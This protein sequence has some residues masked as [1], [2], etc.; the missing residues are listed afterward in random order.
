MQ[1]NSVPDELLS[2][3]EQIDLLDDELLMILAKRFEV[4]EQVGRLKAKEG[5]NSLD[6]DR[7]NQKLKDLK[8]NAESKGLSA[9]FV[10]N[11]FK[12]IFAEVVENH[13]GFLQ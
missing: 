7:E 3:R 13:R 9:D 8:L 5:L 12:M 6:E 10:L 2:L 1:M 4:T 11:L